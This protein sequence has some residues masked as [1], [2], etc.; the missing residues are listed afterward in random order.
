[1]SV[2]NY[3]NVRFD[4][5]ITLGNRITVMVVTE[6]N[7][8]AGKTRLAEIIQHNPATQTVSIKL[9][10]DADV[11]SVPWSRVQCGVAIVPKLSRKSDGKFKKEVDIELM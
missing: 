1:M 8:R 6:G 3:K 4:N 5:A 2:I 11:Y 7:L 10:D 9:V